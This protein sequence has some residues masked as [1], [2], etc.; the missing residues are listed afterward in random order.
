MIGRGRLSREGALD[1]RESRERRDKIVP[2]FCQKNTGKTQILAAESFH[3]FEQ[4]RLLFARVDIGVTEFPEKTAE[5]EEEK[6]GSEIFFPKVKVPG[7]R[8]PVFSGE[9]SFFWPRKN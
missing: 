3:F 1:V 5:K 6:N 7:V 9:F 4:D 2:F 8:N